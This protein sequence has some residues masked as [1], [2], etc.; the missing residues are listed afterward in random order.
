MRIYR[1]VTC[2]YRSP[3]FIFPLCLFPL[4]QT[5][6]N[7]KEKRERTSRDNGNS[8]DAR[9]WRAVHRLRF[10]SAYVSLLKNARCGY[11]MQSFRGNWLTGCALWQVT[12]YTDKHSYFGD[13]PRKIE[14]RKFFRRIASI[15]VLAE[16]DSRSMRSLSNVTIF[17]IM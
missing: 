4:A 11:R 13:G 15:F 7:E 10:L 17:R 14:T 9:R 16:S 8:S 12:W 6:E 3:F 2:L 5:E 1:D